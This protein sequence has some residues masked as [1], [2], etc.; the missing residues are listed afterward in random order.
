MDD[1]SQR[2]GE[3]LFSED[4][5]L[6]PFPMQDGIYFVKQ[7]RRADLCLKS[8]HWHNAIILKI[9]E[10][11]KKDKKERSNEDKKKFISMF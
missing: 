11:E 6:S 10:W 5:N 2:Q 1:Q 8:M 4:R 7:S 3:R 9:S